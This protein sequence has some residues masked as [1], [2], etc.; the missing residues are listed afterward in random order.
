MKV[1]V[2]VPVP[3]LNV[4]SFVQLAFTSRL[5]LAL[6][7]S[8]PLIVMFWQVAVLTSTVTVAPPAIVT[9]SVAVGATPPTHVVPK[10]Q[11]PPAAVDVIVANGFEE[12]TNGSL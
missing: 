10:L 4:P 5:R 9:S 6:K 3:A 2:P 11:L 1:T 7:L 12:V 8:V